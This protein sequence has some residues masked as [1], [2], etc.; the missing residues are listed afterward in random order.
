M[1]LSERRSIATMATSPVKSAP[2]PVRAP[3]PMQDG[4]A[5]KMPAGPQQHDVVGELLAVAGPRHDGGVRPGDPLRDRRRADRSAR[6]RTPRSSRRRRRNNADGK[7]RSPSARRASG[8]VRLPPALQAERN[9]TSR[10]R[11]A[12]GTNSARW[13]DRKIRLKANAGQAEIVAP[14]QPVSASA[15]S[16]QVSHPGPSS[17]HIAVRPRRSGR[18]AA[19]RCFRQTARRIARKSTQASGNSGF[20]HDR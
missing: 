7:P 15:S 5:G 8:H 16:S 1:K 11:P 6:R 13:R 2:R 17:S 19:A 12:R 10:N 9:P 20:E 4:A 3:A 14:D 18:T